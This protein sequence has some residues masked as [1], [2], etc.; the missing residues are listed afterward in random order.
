MKNSRNVRDDINEINGF[1]SDTS[2]SE[3]KAIKKLINI[4]TLELWRLPNYYEGEAE[5]LKLVDGDFYTFIKMCWCY[6]LS[7][8]FRNVSEKIKYLPNWEK[9][10]KQYGYDEVW[11][12]A[13]QEDNV[14][15]K[16]VDKI[17][18][19]DNRKIRTIKNELCP[20]K[21]LSLQRARDK[22]SE[23]LIKQLRAELQKK[24]ALIKEYED[25]VNTIKDKLID[26]PI[27]KKI[28]EK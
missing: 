11:L 24:D 13:R 12:L 15:L 5:L 26:E 18:N 23:N 4:Q 17:D 28:L 6:S 20:T 25:F 14:K 22:N 21:P 7:N 3:L 10:Y 16:I 27:F 19:G 8:K 2:E 9:L 1:I